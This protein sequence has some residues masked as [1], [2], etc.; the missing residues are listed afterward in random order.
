MGPCRRRSA[1][2]FVCRLVENSEQEST[3]SDEEG[4]TSSYR[5]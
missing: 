5:Q 3:Q 2:V 4:S 1:G